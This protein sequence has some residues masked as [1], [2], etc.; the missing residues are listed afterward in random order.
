[1]Q[2]IIITLIYCDV[3]EFRK[4]FQAYWKKHLLSDNNEQEKEF[5][6][7]QNEYNRS[8]D[9][10]DIISLVWFCRT[11]VCL[12]F[13]H[14]CHELNATGAIVKHFPDIS[15]PEPAKLRMLAEG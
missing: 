2:E 3:D 4:I 9:N 13:S 6:P 11:N 8:Y 12:R 7:M 1:M 14:Y 15:A 5:P 10:S